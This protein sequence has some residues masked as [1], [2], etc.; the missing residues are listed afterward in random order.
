MKFRRFGE[1]GLELTA[2]THDRI[3]WIDALKGF[4]IFCVTA[5]HCNLWAPVE[6]YIYSFHMF[7]FFFLSGFLFSANGTPAEMIRKRVKRLLVPFLLWNTLCASI[8][9]FVNRDFENYVQELFVL[10]GNL[11]WNPPIWFLL[12]LFIAETVCILCRLCRNRKVS[13]AAMVVCL[14]LWIMV[15]DQFLLW[16][17]NL[18]PMAIAFFLFGYLFKTMLPLVQKWYVLILLGL[19]SVVFA[20]SNIRIVYTYGRFGNYLYCIL[21]AVC[22]VLSLVGM[23]SA[24]AFLGRLKF[25]RDWGRNSLWIMATQ[26]FVF[27][28]VS[29]ISSKV[30]GIDLMKQ[31]GLVLSVALPLFTMWATWMSNVFI[32]RITRNSEFLMRIGEAFGIQYP[33]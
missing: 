33:Y 2:K 19:G 31:E 17:L 27:K 29:I 13:A 20:A 25:L 24:V 6:K 28:A 1:I 22:G 3:E 5:G 16:K 30:L 15:G 23:F 4:A 14:G 32:K 7:L 18:V 9:F 21:A 11:T 10:K 12:V 26:F 8:T